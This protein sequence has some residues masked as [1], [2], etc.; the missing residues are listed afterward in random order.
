MLSSRTCGQFLVS[1]VALGT[2]LVACTSL[3]L[4]QQKCTT[5]LEC[6][7][8]SVDIAAR[9]DA[10]LASIEGRLSKLETAQAAL[11]NGRILA[12]AEIKAGKLYFSSPGVSYDPGSGIFAFLNP[13]R[14]CRTLSST[15]ISPTPI[16]LRR[17]WR[18][19]NLLCGRRPWI[20]RVLIELPIHTTSLLWLSDSRQLGGPEGTSVFLAGARVHSRA[21][22]FVSVVFIPKWSKEN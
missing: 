13:C 19:T 14:C 2:S 12:M 22:R 9:V 4:A 5:T 17:Y 7:Q 15:R 18:R 8:Q 6:A 16:G 3:S 1:L 20:R 11:G 21:S 10:A